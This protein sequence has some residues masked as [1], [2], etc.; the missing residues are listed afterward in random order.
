MRGRFGS[1]LLAVCLLSPAVARADDCAT[2]VLEP[3]LA[4]IGQYRVATIAKVDEGAV[5]ILVLGE[6][7]PVFLGIGVRVDGDKVQVARELVNDQDLRFNLS[8]E[9]ASAIDHLQ[10]AV[11]QD[12]EAL[13]CSDLMASAGDWDKAILD[14]IGVVRDGVR[15]DMEARAARAREPVAAVQDDNER[16]GDAGEVQGTTL[17][18]WVRRAR[19]A[20]ADFAWSAWTLARALVWDDMAWP[21]VGDRILF[22]AVLLGAPILLAIRRLRRRSGD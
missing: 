1:A 5:A 15:S 19:A 13:S 7:H 17:S 14:R 10:S 21:L 20:L 8:P 18:D 3:K 16:P 12:P 22:P 6:G 11:Q 2:S 4:G 9:D